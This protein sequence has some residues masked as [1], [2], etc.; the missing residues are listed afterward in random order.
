MS[1]VTL[2]AD[3]LLAQAQRQGLDRGEAAQLM[4]HAVGRATHDRAWLLAH[5]GDALKPDQA[6]AFARF[7]ARRMDGEPVAYITGFQAFYGLSLAVGPGVL[8]PRPDTETLVD[9]A[10]ECMDAATLATPMPYEVRVA[11]WGTGSG[12]IALA[13]QAQRPQAQV[14][15]LERSPVALAQAQANAQR[16]GLNQVHWVLG[17]WHAHADTGVGA[18]EAVRLAGGLDVLVSNPPY[19]ELQDPHVPALRHE[20]QEALVSGVDGLVDIRR[21]IDSA[22]DWVKPGG[23]LLLEHGWNQGPA[24]RD[25]FERAGWLSVSQ[26]RDLAG[27]WRCTGAMRP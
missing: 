26:R 18:T 7:C 2:T 23:W 21:I 13:L 6:D 14:W 3:L 16:L 22:P 27:H 4:L 15:A 11:D 9:W 24:V 20:P 25:L 5:G 1:T 10:L 19:I 12:A 17:D 8:V